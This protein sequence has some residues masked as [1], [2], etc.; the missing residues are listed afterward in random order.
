[1]LF[2]TK[3]RS[4]QLFP[5]TKPATGW[6]PIL[7]NPAFAILERTAIIKQTS[8]NPISI[9]MISFIFYSFLVMIY[10]CIFKPY[11]KYTLFTTKVNS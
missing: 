7:Y 2:K 9:L 11:I 6:I 5:K 10:C 3:A 1:M 4:R 8:A